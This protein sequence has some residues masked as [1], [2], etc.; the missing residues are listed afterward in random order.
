MLEPSTHSLSSPNTSP[1]FGYANFSAASSPGADKD[2]SLGYSKNSVWYDTET[3]NIYLCVDA[4]D[5]AA[6]WKLIRYVPG[7]SDSAT[8]TDTGDVS[9]TEEIIANKATVLTLNLLFSA[10]TVFSVILKNIG[11]GTAT[12]TSEDSETFGGASD[13][14]LETGEF[15]VLVSTGTNWI[16]QRG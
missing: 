12:F 4:T 16:R 2:S 8:Y 3:G 9:Y 1:G 14:V 13:L 11:A 6:V 5:E 15:A 10:T 7:S